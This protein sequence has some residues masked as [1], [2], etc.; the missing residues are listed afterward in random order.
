MA[1]SLYTLSFHTYIFFAFLFTHTTLF[2]PA[3]LSIKEIAIESQTISQSCKGTYSHTNANHVILCHKT[4][5]VILCHKKPL[6]KAG[7]KLTMT[8]S[9]NSFFSYIYLSYI[10][11]HTLHTVFILFDLSI[12]EFCVL[13][14]DLFHRKVL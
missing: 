9:I 11:F 2:T 3:H 4:S 13:T 1:Y 6:I 14:S 8:Q 7:L 12:K 5:H 10:S